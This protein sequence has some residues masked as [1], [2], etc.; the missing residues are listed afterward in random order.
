MQRWCHP[1]RASSAVLFFCSLR[2]I[3]SCA[4][5]N[6]QPAEYVHQNLGMELP[7]MAPA[8]GAP[9]LNPA[10][11]PKYV[12]ALVLPPVMPKASQ[13]RRG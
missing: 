1:M 3:L 4:F 9:V 8:G 11:I 6:W 5:A 2:I 7:A 10:C 13:V 12:D